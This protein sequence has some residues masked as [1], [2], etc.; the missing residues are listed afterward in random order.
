MKVNHSYGIIC[1][2][3]NDKNSVI[4]IERLN[5]IEYF[6]II[7]G[8]YK[9]LD[10]LEEYL[11]NITLKEFSLLSSDKDFDYIWKDL[12]HNRN[13]PYTELQKV[14]FQRLRRVVNFENIKNFIHKNNT[15]LCIPK[16]KKLLYWESDLQCALREFKEETGIC[17]KY[18]TLRDQY[19]KHDYVGSDL[20]N[21]SILYYLADLN[22]PFKKFH[23]LDFD[24]GEV[25]KVKVLNL[26]DSKRYIYNRNTIDLVNNIINKYS[27][28]SK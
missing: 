5:S 28:F 24:K 7:T 15:E 8:K 12:W 22:I 11:I 27:L 18:I 3:K 13:V 17:N 19:Y 25:N 23:N 1:F 26:E 20:N 2:D 14:K 4:F 21:Y 16:G 9:G 10:E 6:N